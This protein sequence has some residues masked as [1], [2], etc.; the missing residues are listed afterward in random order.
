MKTTIRNQRFLK[1]V[2]P[3]IILMLVTFWGFAQQKKKL[4]ILN[5]DIN[6]IE[7]TPTDAGNLVRLEME[8]LDTFE[9]TDRYDVNYLIKQK[10]L[11]IEDCYGKLCLVEL[12]NELNSDYM[13]SGTIEKFTKTIIISF[14]LIDVKN[15][16][17]VTSHVQEYLP[18]VEE[19]QTMINVSLR[20]LFSMEVAKN[21]EIS[22]SKIDSYE[23]ARNN[24]NVD[25]LNLSGPRS[26]FS[27][28]TGQNGKII[29]QSEAQGGFNSYPL[30]YMFGYQFE[31]QYLNEGNYQALFEIVPAI[32]GFTNNIFRPSL[33]ILNG[34]RNNKNGLEVA[35]GPTFSVNTVATG[36]YDN[37]NKWVRVRD[38]SPNQLANANIITRVDSRGEPEFNSNLLFAVGKT[39]KSGKV[40][41]PLNLFFIPSRQ[42][43]IVGFTL[44]F[45][46]KR[47]R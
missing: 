41:I 4:T 46:S 34:F 42:G 29:T 26:G 18:I 24:P 14:R 28:L 45:N 30:L 10:N 5:M 33:N 37:Q 22:L 47:E 1:K 40:N 17:I 8:K 35:F 9:I 39:I 21:V 27:Y 11:S 15:S 31:V 36:F 16:K 2:L 7:L 25:K 3:S 32:T 38:A 6:G 12:G 23:S 13:L 20:R 43:S 44:G 19:L